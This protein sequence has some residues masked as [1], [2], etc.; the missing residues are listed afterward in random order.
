MTK[1][2]LL[3]WKDPAVWLITELRSFMQF[4]CSLI[5]QDIVERYIIHPFY[6]QNSDLSLP[7]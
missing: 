4:G 2:L 1:L 3:K 6:A 5:G 7:V